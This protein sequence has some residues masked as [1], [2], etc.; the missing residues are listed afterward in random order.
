M[1]KS[2]INKIENFLSNLILICIAAFGVV[3]IYRLIKLIVMNLHDLFFN[4]SYCFFIS[5]VSFILVICLEI[6]K[7][8]ISE[9]K[10]NAKKSSRIKQK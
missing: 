5:I 8:N 9:K 6:L 3:F 7:D 2:I 1:K 4:V 10:H